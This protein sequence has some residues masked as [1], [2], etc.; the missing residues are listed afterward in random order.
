MDGWIVL[1]AL[2]SLLGRAPKRMD[3]LMYIS[4]SA[5]YFLLHLLSAGLLYVAFSPLIT[6]LR[7]TANTEVP[8]LLSYLL[9]LLLIVIVWAWVTYLKWRSRVSYFQRDAG[10]SIKTIMAGWSNSLKWKG[11]IV[12]LLIISATA[13]I[14]LFLLAIGAYLQTAPLLAST[15]MAAMVC[16]TIGKFYLLF[17]LWNRIAK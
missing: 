14:P 2:A 6:H 13:G 7:L 11:F 10:F 9:L 4:T 3:F 12:F 16:F 17:N 15:L 8:V 5:F 1:S